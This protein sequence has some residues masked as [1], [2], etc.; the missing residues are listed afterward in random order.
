MNKNITQ[1]EA[2]EIL[3]SNFKQ[4]MKRKSDEIT[5]AQKV[6]FEK[7]K[8]Y[9]NQKV[10]GIDSQDTFFGTATDKIFEN[11]LYRKQK[12]V[13]MLIMYEIEVEVN[14]QKRSGYNFRINEL[15]ERQDLNYWMAK[16][17]N[18]L[19]MIQKTLDR[20]KKR[21]VIN[22]YKR[23]ERMKQNQCSCGSKKEK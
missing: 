7:L 1:K 9:I 8:N 2:C 18:Q 23:D 6:F 5:E 15:H 17:E 22:D 4:T 12:N 13:K 14:D 20:A 10:K 3:M 16:M 21:K 19:E 11:R